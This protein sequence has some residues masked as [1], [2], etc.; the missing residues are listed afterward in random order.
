MGNYFLMST[1]FNKTNPEDFGLLPNGKGYALNPID[2]T[3]WKSMELYDF[4]WGNEFGYCKMPMPSFETLY[5]LLF[6]S[7]DEDKY[8]AAAV[9][10]A[11]YPYQLLEKCES[12]L[13][14][15]DHGQSDILIEVFDLTNPVNRCPI[16]GKELSE[17]EL[18]AERWRRIAV[19]ANNSAYPK[20]PSFF[21]ILG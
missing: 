11:S 20:Q 10:L 12:T 9:I 1:R 19:I 21:R 8:G 4:G 13:T 18:D 7:C 6:S 5:A 2:N 14:S 3:M 15:E 16:S 17:I